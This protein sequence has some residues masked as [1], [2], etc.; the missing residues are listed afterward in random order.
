MK[1]IFKFQEYHLLAVI[2]LVTAVSIIINHDY[3]M[4]EGFLWD[5]TTRQWIWISVSMPIFH[6]TYVWL[7]WRL[8]LY[9]NWFTRKLGE[10]AFEIYYI[11]FAGLFI[12]RFIFIVFLAVS[13]RGSLYI[14]PWIAYL[15]AAAITPVVVY[16]FYSVQKYFTI[17]RAFGIDHFR[18]NFRKPFIKEGIFRYSNNAMYSFGLWILYLPGLLLLSRAAL[19]VAL[20]NHA[21]IWVHYFCT[22]R[23]DMEKIYGKLPQ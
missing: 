19:L 17:E 18:K 1:N 11:G 3:S 13:N 23:P 21:Y 4:T 2:V 15:A 16:L 10:S 9:D 14:Y 7:V 12:S 8:E 6:Q 22:E 5:L 20:F